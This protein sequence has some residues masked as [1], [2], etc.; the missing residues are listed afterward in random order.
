M[1][2]FEPRISGVVSD[3][4]ANRALTIP[5]PLSPISNY[6]VF[7]TP[8]SSI[9]TVTTEFPLISSISNYS[10]GVWRFQEK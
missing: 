5:P 4:T 6:S 7:P 2:G 3:R 9:S 8:F 1:P 10:P